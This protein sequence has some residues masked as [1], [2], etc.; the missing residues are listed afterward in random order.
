MYFKD[1]VSISEFDSCEKCLSFQYD[2]P[3]RVDKKL[4]ICLSTFLG[5]N[6]K[7]L[8]NVSDMLNS[9]SILQINGENN[10]KIELNNN[11]RYFK[12]YI[13][14]N[15]LIVKSEIEE[16]LTNWISDNLGIKIERE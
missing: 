13:S 3:C 15:D 12:L 8:E 14:Y 4:I 9:D 2:L 11:S 7:Q 16:I 5:G 10:I 1:I 6:K